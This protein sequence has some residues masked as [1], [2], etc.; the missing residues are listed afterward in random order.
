MFLSIGIYEV[1]DMTLKILCVADVQGDMKI[2]KNIEKAI[3][4][5]KPD[6]VINAG[7]FMDKRDSK[8]IFDKTKVKTFFVHG[9]WDM[10]LETDNEENVSILNNMMEEY[11]GYYFLGVDSRF[12]F[13]KEMYEITKDID[14]SK[15]VLIT[16]E[17]PFGILDLSY[18]GNNAG[19][20]EFRE[21]TD[22]KCPI[23]HVFGHIHESSGILEHEKTLYVNAAALELKRVY[24]VTL[25][26]MEVKEIKV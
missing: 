24:L 21:F 15:L 14:P 22:T 25:P 3:K 7:D 4:K 13:H 8:K 5:H 19:L 16:H 18:L 23:M 6:V 2:W 20:I 10:N 26:E 9:N 17:P 12:F 1:N 11:K